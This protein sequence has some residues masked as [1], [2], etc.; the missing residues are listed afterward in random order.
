MESHG[1]PI[2]LLQSSQALSNRVVVLNT[3]Y[4]GTP[5]HSKSCTFVCLSVTQIITLGPAG[6]I[7]KLCAFF[8]FFRRKGR[9]MRRNHSNV[10]SWSETILSV[11]LIRQTTE[12]RWESQ[13]SEVPRKGQW[14]AEGWLLHRLGQWQ[15]DHS[16]AGP[17]PGLSFPWERLEPDERNNEAVVFII[18]SGVREAWSQS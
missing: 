14:E 1:L 6:R 18:G 16:K 17:F 11:R 3:A 4:P 5:H 9:R 13:E 10:F 15:E 12:A 2:M 8:F 7:K